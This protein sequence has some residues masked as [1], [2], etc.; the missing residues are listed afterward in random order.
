MRNP[1]KPSFGASPPLLAGRDDALAEFAGS[2]D[3]GPGAAG[4]ATLYTG[5]RGAGKTAMLNAVEEEARTRGWVVVSETATRG[6]V[7]RLTKSRLPELLRQFDP[8][9]IKHRLSQVSAPVIGGGIG[10]ETIESH[11]AEV[12]LRGQINLLTDLLTEGET[13]LLLTVDE[14]HRNQIDE[15]RE[16]ATVIQHAFREDRDVAFAAA[17]LGSSVSDLL[18][19]DV[20]TFLR[21]ADRYHLGAVELHEVRRALEE[22]IVGSGREVEPV[23][24]EAMVEGTQGYPFLIQLVGSH[25]WRKAG[26]K[27]KP[28]AL[29]AAQDGVASARRRLGALVHDPAFNDVS[30]IDRS[31]LLAMAKDDG[32]SKVA[33]ITRRM[34]VADKYA[35]VY[36]ARLIGA[37]LIE[38]TSHGYVDFTLPYLREYL[39]EHA[40]S[41][42]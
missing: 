9:T 34:G 17:G 20:L 15:L 13:G 19:D 2:L 42:I 35:G 8:D 33:D 23:A 32:P 31:F 14:I 26:R 4:R 27:G 24:L 39:R 41:Q 18:E 38:S 6:L 28:I 29:P 7:E 11:V 36:R 5:A 1:F 40:A 10:W 25:C 37:E 3:D 12:D 16:I 30:D 21:R 22:P